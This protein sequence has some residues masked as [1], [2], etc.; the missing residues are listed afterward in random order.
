MKTAERGTKLEAINKDVTMFVQ[1]T[2]SLIIKTKEDMV[3]ATEFLANIVARKKRVEE[4][5]LSYTKPL[6]E[7]LSNINADFKKA[8]VP[9]INAENVVK[10]KM[11]DY[12]KLE[13]DRLEKIRLAEEKR[14]RKINEKEAEKQRKIAEKEAEKERKRLAKESISKLR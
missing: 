1:K 3:G 12:R 13:F 7:T 6:N 2:N 9:L 5:R 8:S 14:Q 11:V 4:I 10:S